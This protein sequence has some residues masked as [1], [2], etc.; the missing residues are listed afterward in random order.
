MGLKKTLSEEMEKAIYK[1]WLDHG[2]TYEIIANR[3]ETTRH[4]VNRI[5]NEKVPK[6]QPEY[7][8]P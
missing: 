4:V 8:K 7:L 3:F 6:K 2:E 1:T 5:I